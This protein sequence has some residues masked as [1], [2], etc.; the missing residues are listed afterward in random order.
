MNQL[1]AIFGV[2]NVAR[3]LRVWNMLI[4]KITSQ[5]IQQ[6]I[7]ACRSP[8][9]A[10]RVFVNHYFTRKGEERYQLET[11][12]SDLHQR[13]DEDVLDYLSRASAI[14]LKLESYGDTRDDRTM[15]AHI[16]RHLSDTY[17]RVRDFLLLD[18][19]L[20]SRKLEEV[21]RTASHEKQRSGRW[22]GRDGSEERI[23]LVAAGAGRS[24]G[25]SRA[26]GLDCWER[27]RNY[28]PGFF[29]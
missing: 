13:E 5:P 19:S 21:L 8:Q 7:L 3:S 10:W 6:E 26:G 28:P 23:A 1:R 20:S 27:N 2:E 11:R 14:R 22:R 17:E 4:Q 25:A 9:Q 29:C 15:C 12:W 16:A 18:V 24:S